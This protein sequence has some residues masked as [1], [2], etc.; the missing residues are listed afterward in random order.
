MSWCLPFSLSAGSVADGAMEPDSVVTCDV[1]YRK[2][3]G[4]IKGKRRLR[5]DA[6]SLERFV[7]TFQFPV[8]LRIIGRC[9]YLGHPKQPDELLKVLGNELRAVVRDNPGAR[10]RKLLFG[11][12]DDDFYVGF[13]HPTP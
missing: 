13:Q 3:L 1:L 8:R 11:P 7:E 4:I 6:F 9:S 2:S 12:F 5:T 10:F